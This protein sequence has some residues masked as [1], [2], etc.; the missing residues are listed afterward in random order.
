[1]FMSLCLS[2]CGRLAFFKAKDSKH[3]DALCV[4]VSVANV[5]IGAH[6]VV[7]PL[8]SLGATSTASVL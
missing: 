8:I 5:T 7:L 6:K 1:M 3:Y 2:E 4:L